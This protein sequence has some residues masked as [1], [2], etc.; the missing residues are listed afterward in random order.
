MFPRTSPIRHARHVGAALAA[1]AFT[2]APL[3]ASNAG[4]FLTFQMQPGSP[5]GINEVLPDPLGL[6]ARQA[7]SVETGVASG[8][9]RVQPG[10]LQS[11]STASSLGIGTG[12]AAFASVLASLSDTVRVSGPVSS[13]GTIRAEVWLDFDRSFSFSGMRAN[14]DSGYAIASFAFSFFGSS[15]NYRETFWAPRIVDCTSPQSCAPAVDPLTI[16]NNA[17]ATWLSSS[18]LKLLLPIEL[19]TPTR[20]S[21]E[22]DTRAYSANDNLNDTRIWTADAG[23]SLYWGGIRR[24]IDD[25]GNSVDFT[26]S[27]DS[28]I[29][30]RQSFIPATVAV[31]LPSG[32]V[33]MALGLGLLATRVRARS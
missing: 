2:L 32:L 24:L 8:S 28:G 30:Y 4:T 18:L 12:A 7:G 17:S 1:F 26:L 19:E 31:P 11:F 3:S 25:Q 10:V 9:G 16:V 23:N 14:Q 33:L 6:V 27:S 15:I 13:P 20:L 21:L 5:G 22:L 29:D